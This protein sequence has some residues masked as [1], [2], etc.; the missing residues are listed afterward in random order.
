MDN[1][2]HSL[3][4]L[5]IARIAPQREFPQ[6]AAICVVA[7]NI[8]DLDI[9]TV[10]SPAVYLNYHRHLTHSLVA[11]PAMAALTVILVG[12]W[13][14]LHGNRVGHDHP[15]WFARSW[16]LALLAAAWAITA[17]NSYYR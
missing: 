11:I 6:A 3:V 5:L 7:A 13:N 8:P 4:G 10:V 14:R 2:T 15:R 9:V 12:A 16:G 1:L 17:E